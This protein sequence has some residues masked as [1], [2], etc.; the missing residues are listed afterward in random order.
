MD[1]EAYDGHYDVAL[2]S[3][4]MHTWNDTYLYYDGEK[5]REYGAVVL[6]EEEFLKSYENSSDVL[7]AIRQS[8]EIAEGESLEITSIFVRGNGIVQ[9]QC[10]HRFAYGS[11]DF[12]YFEY[13]SDE[14]NKLS[15][16]KELIYGQ[17]GAVLSQLEAV[18][19]VPAK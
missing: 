16:G 10:E 9:I 6:T 7:N 3:Y 4:I 14:H 11:I 12:F 2:D 13:K 8:V 18:Y 15:G 19:P 5:Y 1:I 17:M